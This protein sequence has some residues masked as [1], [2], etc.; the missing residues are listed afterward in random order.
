MSLSDVKPIL[1]E[2]AV[3]LPAANRLR[4]SEHYVFI[5][6]TKVAVEEELD[7]NMKVEELEYLAKPI[8]EVAVSK[9]T[10][11]LNKLHHDLGRKVCLFLVPF[12]R[13]FKPRSDKKLI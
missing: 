6:V 9:L 13:L 12:V 7:D 8:L 5:G 3:Q 4:D 10:R 2:K 11:D 1:W